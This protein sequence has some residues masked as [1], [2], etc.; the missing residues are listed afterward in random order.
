[1]K[2]TIVGNGE[3]ALTNENGNFID[4]CDKVVRIKNFKTSGFEKFIGEKIDMFS[5]KWF[6]WYDRNTNEPLKFD[7]IEDVEKFIFMFFNPSLKYERH[8]FSNFSEYVWDYYRLQLKNEFPSPIGSDL[9]HYEKIREYNIDESRI[10]YMTP[11]DIHDLTYNMLKIKNDYFRKD[12]NFESLIEP[13][14]GIRTI[15]KILKMYPNDEIFI[16]GFDGFQTSWYWNPNH[17]VN[18]AHFYLNERI[19]LKYL[20]NKKNVKNLDE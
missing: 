2:I 12:V 5:S 18:N 10:E 16:T 1:M 6:S 15:Y 11:E 3:C 7:F 17:K 14:V 8:Q 20:C 4:N 9:L 19:L 13:T